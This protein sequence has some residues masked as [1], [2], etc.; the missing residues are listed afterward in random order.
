MTAKAQIRF[1][2]TGIGGVKQAPKILQE[3]NKQ[4]IKAAEIPFTYRVWMDNSQAKEIGQTAKKFGIMLSIHAPY[5]I[6]LASLDKKKIEASKKR[7]LNCC[8]KGHYLG[9]KYIVF[10]A[11]YYSGKTEEECFNIV[12]K[13]IQE[14]QHVIKHKGWNVKLAPETTGKKSQFGSLEELLK[15]KRQTGCSLC[16]DFAHLYARECGKIN[17]KEIFEKIKKLGHIH[18]HFSGIEFTAKGE[19]RHLITPESRLKELLGWIKK[20]KIDVT[21]INESPSPFKDSLKGKR[22]WEKL[23]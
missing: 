2:P 21:I 11:A 9:A 18:A 10:H 22:I 20:Y 14:M 17:Y 12:K 7:I 4:G 1:G 15:L 5:Y 23:K 8:E 3:Y 13:Q 19:K 6:N 16:I